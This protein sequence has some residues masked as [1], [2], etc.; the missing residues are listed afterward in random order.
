MQIAGPTPN[1]PH[2]VPPPLPGARATASDGIPD[3][4]KGFSWG[5]LLLNWIWAIGNRTWIG[6]LALIPYVGFVVAIWLGF[7]GREMAWENK[8]WDSVEHFNRVQKRWSQWGVG[9]MI[10]SLLIGI[11]AAIS[12]PAYQDYVHRAKQAAAEADSAQAPASEPA[13]V[14]ESAPVAA[15]APP[16]EAAPPDV[17]NEQ[18]K[19]GDNHGVMSRPDFQNLVAGKSADEVLQILGKPDTTQD[20]GGMQIWYYQGKTR[21]PVTDNIDNM[22]QITFQHNYVHLVSFM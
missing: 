8:K 11:L 12:I 6:L 13:P 21:D 14:A 17:P 18:S 3:G 7:K 16:A 2:A 10:G 20:L 4:I 15:A 5:A 22:A 9:I 19:A 1:D